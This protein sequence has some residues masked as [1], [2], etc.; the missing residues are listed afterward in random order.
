MVW[1]MI[2]SRGVSDLYVVDGMMQQGQYC[3]VLESHMLPKLTEWFDE[4]EH[5][6]F[7][8]DSAPCHTAKSV[9]NFLSEFDVEILPWP[10]NSPDLNPIENV[11]FFVKQE[12]GKF[13]I[14]NKK[15][16]IE[17]LFEVW[18]MPKI[19]EI[20]RQCIS[21]MPRRVEAVRKSRGN[22]TKY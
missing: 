4:G 20:A 16:L 14:T 8:Q 10:G 7:M 11:W 21:S 12:L 5:P 18:A 9:R 13:T 22:V 15:E 3:R 19:F 17:K 6:V 1:G 2:S